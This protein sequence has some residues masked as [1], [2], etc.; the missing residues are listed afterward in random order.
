VTAYEV[1]LLFHLAAVIGFFSGVAVAAAAQLGALRRQRPGEIAAVLGLARTG[2]LVV[3]VATLLVLATGLWLIEETGHSL[4]DGWLSLSLL[5][6]VVAG[7][8]GAVGGRKPKEAR[9][10][11]E[12]QA[13]AETPDPAIRTL[14]LDP[15][16]L[17]ANVLSAAAALAIL[18]LMVWR[19]S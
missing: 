18:V 3:G 4:G 13:G 6:L 2:V 17:L 16:S 14:L 12:S 7:A 19:P 11:A 5:L 8:L 10:L 1:A 15:V 9:K